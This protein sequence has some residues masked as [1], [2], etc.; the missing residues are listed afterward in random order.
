MLRGFQIKAAWRMANIN[1]RRKLNENTWEYPAS[2]EVHKE[3]GL[4][5][6]EKEVGLFTIEHYI[7][8]RCN[9]LTEYKKDRDIYKH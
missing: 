4:F 1:K 6:I 3:V 2:E 5:T 9:T 8:K 7:Q